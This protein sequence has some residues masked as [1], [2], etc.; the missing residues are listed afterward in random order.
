MIINQ[1]EDIKKFPCTD[2]LCLSI[3]KQYMEDNFTLPIS[4]L[5]QLCNKC[6]LL[7]TYIYYSSPDISK[8]CSITKQCIENFFIFYNVEFRG[9]YE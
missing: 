3:C 6:V 8:K 4:A 5:N 7:N 2:C 1:E 9:I